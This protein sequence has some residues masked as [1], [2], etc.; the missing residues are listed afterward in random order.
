MVNSVPVG[1]IHWA[2][3]NLPRS[4]GVTQPSVLRVLEEATGRVSK[5]G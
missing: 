3:M 5:P 1:K 2:A 4:T